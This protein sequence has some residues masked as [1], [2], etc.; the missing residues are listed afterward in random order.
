MPELKK[1]TLLELLNYGC[2]NYPDKLALATVDGYEL[3]YTELCE[4]IKTVSA[5]LKEIG[6][7]K[8]DRVAILGENHPHWGVA[9]FAITTIGATAV[10]IM[11]EFHENEIHHILRHSSAKAIFISGKFFAKIEFAQAEELNERILMDDFS[12]I[13]PDSGSDLVKR[14]MNEGMKE[15]KKIRDMALKFLGKLSE[16]PEE[17]DP[18][19]LI[20]TSGT[21][22]HSKGVLLSHKNLV[23]D[24]LGTLKIVEVNHTDSMMSIL[25]LAHTYECTLGL[26]TPV[27]KGASVYYLEKPPTAGV[28]L[29]A[30]A[31]KKPTFILSVPL[32]IEKIFR[33]RVL[34]EIKKKKLVWSL[35]KIPA[36]RKKI[37][38]AAGKK[39]KKTFGG[40]LRVFTIGGAPLA[41]DVE[42]FLREAKFP[43]AMGYGLTETAPLV[44]GT[45]PDHTRY[46]STGVPLPG[47]EVKLRDVNEETGEGEI[48][49]KGPQVMLGYFKDEEKTKE[50]LDSDG[51]FR[52]GDL[53]TIDKDGYV[54]IKGRSKNVII[55]AN[56][57]N[58]YPE[59]IE[60]ILNQNPYIVES[61]VLE[62][63]DGL[64]AKVV[65][66]Y[67]VIDSE[68]ETKN[69]NESEARVIIADILKN[70][71]KEINTRVPGYSKIKNIQEQPEPFEKTPTQK[72]KRYL[73][74]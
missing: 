33:M 24:A 9:Y 63:A 68:F 20:Y 6:I 10:P 55:G 34:P 28:L 44:I 40:R 36:V 47:V 21:T 35:Y 58:I 37:N 18:A 26:I 61:L 7:E 4:K 52:T 15:F 23:S 27:L 3:T 72:I 70:A 14:V 51:W 66:D 59:E 56:G 64:D 69:K 32:V 73:Y 11:Q 42:L 57:K 1:L 8:G 19:S 25:P 54:Y 41:A 45:N 46:R 50:V 38:A 39:L 31:K 65:L 22:G 17:N 60:S 30:L 53:G 62:R 2:A 74:Q 48:L 67:D 13:P 16:E 71:L 29:P 43:Y 12:I 5:F 49:I